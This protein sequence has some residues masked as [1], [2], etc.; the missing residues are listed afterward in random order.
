MLIGVFVVSIVLGI[1][2]ELRRNVVP[3]MIAHA[4]FDA[5]QLFLIL[6]LVVRATTA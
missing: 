2:F 3:C 4:V 6:P 1:V 5:I